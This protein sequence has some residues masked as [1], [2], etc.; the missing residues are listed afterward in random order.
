M[1]QIIS[2]ADLPTGDD[3][4]VVYLN[5]CLKLN[6]KPRPSAPF[7]TGA[8]PKAADSLADS[9]HGQLGSWGYGAKGYVWGANWQQEVRRT[10]MGA[11][12][13]SHNDLQRQG[14]WA[15]W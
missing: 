8:L 1:L 6:E 15:C 13:L 4:I 10:I 5:T 11:Q 9:P 7:S 14:A 12:V 2:G 3:G